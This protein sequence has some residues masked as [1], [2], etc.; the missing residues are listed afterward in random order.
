MA[1]RVVS[2]TPSPPASPSQSTWLVGCLDET[3]VALPRTALQTVER[4]PLSPPP[5]WSAPWV[6]GLAVHGVQ[7]LVAL[8][9]NGLASHGADHPRDGMMAIVADRSW[10]VWIDRLIGFAAMNV[11][12]ASHRQPP[13]SWPCP[14]LWLRPLTLADGRHVWA[15]DPERVTAHLADMP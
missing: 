12:P 15:V 14:V 1:P 13:A 9:L 5:P 6:G 3:L 10:A 2:A 4:C 8:R 11:S 7:P